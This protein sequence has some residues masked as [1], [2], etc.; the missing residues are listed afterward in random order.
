MGEC[1]RALVAGPAVRTIRGKLVFGSKSSTPSSAFVAIGETA[2]MR[3][4]ST[5]HLQRNPALNILF[6]LHGDH[7]GNDRLEL[8]NPA[9]SM[10]TIA[11]STA[12]P[13]E[14]SGDL[15]NYSAMRA[16]SCRQI[17]LFETIY[18][19][20]VE[21]FD[22]GIAGQYQN[23]DQLSLGVFRTMLLLGF[24]AILIGMAAAAGADRSGAWYFVTQFVTRYVD[25]LNHYGCDETSAG[26]TKALI[27]RCPG[28]SICT[29]HNFGYHTA[30]HIRP[31]A[32]WTELPGF[33]THRGQNYRNGTSS[34]SAGQG[35]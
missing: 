14:R 19:Q 2:T 27:I 4:T 17:S 24:V 30:H 10:A 18:A 26:P 35:S 13:G 8:A 32:H 22:K 12:L 3:L 20:I 5:G 16:V 11:A 23:S 29:T 28:G 1:R 25:Y 9:P 21:S 15:K 6:D 34:R 33:T 31:G 7:H